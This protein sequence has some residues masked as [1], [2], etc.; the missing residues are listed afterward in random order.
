MHDISDLAT[1]LF[2]LVANTYTVKKEV[3]FPLHWWENHTLYYYHH[4]GFACGVVL[5]HFECVI[6]TSTW[7][8]ALSTTILSGHVINM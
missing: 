8:S 2:Y 1:V 3:K 7:W 4:G 5:H 6:T